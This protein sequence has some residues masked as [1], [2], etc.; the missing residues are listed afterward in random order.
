MCT[1]TALGAI[2]LLFVFFS[3]VINYNLIM[4][5]PPDDDKR[6]K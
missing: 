4:S 3:F 1:V 2:F 6:G 5:A